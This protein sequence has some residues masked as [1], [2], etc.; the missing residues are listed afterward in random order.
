M[1]GFRFGHGKQHYSVRHRSAG[2]PALA[3][4]DNVMRSGIIQG[5]PAGHIAGIAAGHWLGQAISAD[6]LRHWPPA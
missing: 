1:S 4:I 3:P 6:L 2:H 5:S